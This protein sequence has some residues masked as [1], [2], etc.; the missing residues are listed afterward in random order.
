MIAPYPSMSV[1]NKLVEEIEAFAR[2]NPGHEASVNALLRAV[3]RIDTEFT[4]ETR[5]LLLAEARKTFLQQIE[6]LET[7]NRTLAALET[8]Q[9]NQQELVTALKR[10]AIRRPDGVTLH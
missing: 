9:S 3:N 7:T 8:L 2:R 6:T 1:A 4:G 10:L 5:E